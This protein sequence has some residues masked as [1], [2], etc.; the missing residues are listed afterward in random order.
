MHGERGVQG[1]PTPPTPFV[2]YVSSPLGIRAHLPQAPCGS[3]ASLSWV[4][5]GEGMVGAAADLGEDS[6]GPSV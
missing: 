2:T 3:A 1:P 4:P 6:L 5:K